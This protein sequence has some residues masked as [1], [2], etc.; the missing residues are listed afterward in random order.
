MR[1]VTSETVKAALA[2]AET[3][4]FVMSTLHT[5]DAAETVNRIIDF[6][7]PHEQKQIRM[8]LV[9]VAARHPLSATGSAV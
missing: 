9:G 5:T 4:H 2:A 1:C 8:T 6:F 3:G 7:P